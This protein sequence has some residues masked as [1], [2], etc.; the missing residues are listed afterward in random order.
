MKKLLS[1]VLAAL[2]IFGCA[3]A[4]AESAA[5]ADAAFEGSWVQFEDGFEI[6][7]PSDWL[8][9]DPTDAMKESG[10]F[11][12]VT[13][14]DGARSMVVAW[15]DAAGVATAADLKT[16]MATVYPTADI[17][18]FNGV[19]FVTYEDT[20]NDGTGIVALDGN[21]GMFIFNFTPRLRRGLRPHRCD[22]RLLYSH[23]RE[24]IPRAVPFMP[25]AAL[26]EAPGV[27]GNYG[28]RRDPRGRRACKLAACRPCA[29]AVSSRARLP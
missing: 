15:A 11:Y 28:L 7:L 1:A 26:K 6:Y 17:L 25:G 10:I 4:L 9:V 3:A 24:L 12:S 18:N 29:S 19:D 16:Q 23:D 20:A 5:P 22:D 13:S 8:V 14:P 21:G 27:W 2:L